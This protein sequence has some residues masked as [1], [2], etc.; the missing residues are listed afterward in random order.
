[1]IPPGPE[2]STSSKKY[3]RA[4]LLRNF[5]YLFVTF[6]FTA[7][8]LLSFYFKRKLTSLS[9]CHCLV[10]KEEEKLPNLD[11]MRVVRIDP[12]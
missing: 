11:I 5:T 12:K 7:K 10:N 4:S 1:M 3:C 8:W 9:L 6:V 2:A